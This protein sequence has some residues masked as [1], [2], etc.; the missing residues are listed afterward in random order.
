MT[1]I[2]R[3][4]H[5][6]RNPGHL[7]IP[8][9]AK[10]P[11]STAWRGL[12]RGVYK[13]WKMSLTSIHRPGATSRRNESGSFFTQRR[14]GLNRHLPHI[15]GLDPGGTLK[16]RLSEINDFGILTGEWGKRGQT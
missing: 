10:H 13:E 6:R 15:D 9:T 14:M 7:G 2:M 3:I 5:L 12:H 11:E 4:L 1:M 16:T 8:K